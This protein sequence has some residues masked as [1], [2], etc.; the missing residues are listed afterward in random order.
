MSMIN[1]EAAVEGLAPGSSSFALDRRL[2]AAEQVYRLLRNEIITCRLAPY[3]AIS[4]NRICGMFGVSRSPVRVAVTRLAEDGLIEIFPQRGTFVAPIKMTQVR[5]AQFARLAL[6]V[7]LA[8]EAARHWTPQFT[9]EIQQNLVQQAQHASQGDSSSFFHDNESFHQI[10]A[11]AARLEGVWTTIQSVKTVWDRIG[12][13]ANRV[14]AH[15]LEIIAEHRNIVEALDRGNASDAAVTM[16]THM[17]SV[18]H[19]IARLQPL[20][21]N[22]FVA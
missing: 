18:D 2:P 19:A 3:E 16:K 22:Y 14:P 10:I 21:A 11:R 15:T 13:I 6:E 1:V 4:E 9:T 7:A 12:H 5:E 17:K 20:H 8:E